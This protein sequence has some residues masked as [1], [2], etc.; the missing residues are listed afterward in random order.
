[1]KNIGFL[2]FP[3][4]FMSL[5]WHSVSFAQDYIKNYLPEGAIARF[6]KG[7]VFD[8]EYSP[9]GT[10]LAVGSTIGVWL[11]DTQTYKELHLLT[12]HKDFVTGVLFSPDSKTLVSLSGGSWTPSEVKLW[13]VLSGELIATLIDE[14]IKVNHIVFSPDGE[15]LAI[16]SD[17]SPIRLWDVATGEPKTPLIEHGCKVLQFSPDGSKLVGDGGEVIRFWDVATGELQLTFAAHADSVDALKYSPDGTM[18]A[19]HGGDNNVCL[20]DADTGEFLRNFRDNKTGFSIDFSK[21]GKTLAI[22]N[23]DGTLILWNSRTGEKI[24]TVKR[25]TKLDYVAYSPDGKTLACAEGEDG[26][27]LLFDANTAALLH[28][29]EMPGHRKSVNDFWYSSDGRTLAVSNGFEIYFWNVDTGKLQETITGYSEVVGGVMYAP[30]EEKV[31]S[32]DYVVRF[33]DLDTHQ[34]DKKLILESPV[35]SVAYSLDGETL[36]C[37]TYDNTIV[38]W[39]VS[40]WKKRGVLEGHTSGISSMAFSPDGKTLVSGGWDDT[41]RF[42]NVRTGEPLKTLKKHASRKVLFSPNGQ[43]LASVE[44]DDTIH[45]WNVA[46]DELVKTIQ[47]DAGVVVYS[48]DFSPDGTTL[49]TADDAGKISFWDVTIGDRKTMTPPKEKGYYA[50]FSPDGAII[51]SAAAGK[52]SLW[53]VAT[54]ELLKTLTGH[55]DVITAIVFSSDGKTLVSGC[56]DSTVI[57]WDLTE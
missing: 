2:L 19:S 22:V 18:I 50:V 14:E 34:L 20:W 17:N 26:T 16:A 1:M 56:R 23:S 37:G 38:L 31:V 36:A 52:I 8:F 43:I 29:L 25:D 9:D 48:V 53:D 41:I 47:I 55:I 39:N 6:G 21:D 35:S 15:T 33:W 28:S 42:W 49:V 27:M 7:Y 45:L 10:R 24:K 5:L 51:A 12:G 57:L 11:Y 40:E 46:T 3:I 13:N 44:N 30:N 32:S 54:G 4:I